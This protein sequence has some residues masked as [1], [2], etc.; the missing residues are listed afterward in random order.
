[1]DASQGTTKTTENVLARRVLTALMVPL[2]ALVTWTLLNSFDSMY[3]TSNPSFS[4]PD[5]NTGSQESFEAGQEQRTSER[6]APSSEKSEDEMFDDYLTGLVAERYERWETLPSREIEQGEE[7]LVSVSSAVGSGLVGITIDGATLYQNLD[8]F[9]SG[10]G[11]DGDA[12]FSALEDSSLG[13]I[14]RDQFESSR[15]VS[16]DVT[17]RNESVEYKKLVWGNGSE[18]YELEAEDSL[19]ASL[20][21]LEGHQSHSVARSLNTSDEYSVSLPQGENAHI[22][23]NYVLEDGT[24]INKLCACLSDGFPDAD[25]SEAVLFDLGL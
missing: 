24:D 13:G 12:L 16:I 3:S 15:F 8:D 1:M 25:A 22:R 5:E 10:E 17:V 2:V 18:S 6:D 7:G 21:L 14:T 23:L 19:D 20:T 4:I 11:L 9:A